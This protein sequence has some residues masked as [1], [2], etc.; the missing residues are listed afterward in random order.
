MDSGG[1]LGRLRQGLARTR[2]A[3][4]TRLDDLFGR[5]LDE[6]FYDEL[7]ETLI[8]AD[9]GVRTTE[10][11]TARLRE[12]ARAGLRTPEA[13]RAAVAEILAASLGDPIPLVLQPP[14][15]VVLV[16]GVNGSGK[17]TT[18]GKLA[19]RLKQDG[20]K[21][22]L[23]AGDT[24]RA[25]AI[26]QLEVWAER[27][28]VEVIRHQEGA[29]PAAVVY[30]AAQAT[31]ARH[32]DVLIVDTAGRLHTKTNLIEELK[33]IDRVLRRELPGAPIEALLVLDA[34]TGQNGIAQARRFKDALPITGIVLTKL[35]GTARGGIVVAIAEALGLPVKIIGVGEGM[36]DLQPFDPRAFVDALLSPG[37]PAPDRVSPPGGPPPTI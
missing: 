34:T 27:V 20:R 2:E 6:A 28:G 35:D 16:L 17:T 15:A 25:A 13:V 32:V 11:V 5:G 10:T 1:W 30:D 8:R 3:L 14:P 24:F 22:L 21:V 26:D 36:E 12:Q 37:L 23:A 18:I 4:G 19:H 7:E 29:D 9:V 31:R 33:K